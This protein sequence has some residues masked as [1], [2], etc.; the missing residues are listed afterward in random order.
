[1]AAS[2]DPEVKARLIKASN[3]AEYLARQIQY[4]EVVR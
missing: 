4:A 1:L 2:R 3:N